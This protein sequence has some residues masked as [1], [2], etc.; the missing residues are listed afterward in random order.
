MLKIWQISNCTFTFKFSILVGHSKE[1][2]TIFFEM[3]DI[4]VNDVWFYF[5]V[6]WNTVFLFKTT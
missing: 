3:Q 5:E 6:I 2:Y 1:N 4:S